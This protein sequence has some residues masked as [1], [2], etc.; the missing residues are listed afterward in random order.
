[1]TLWRA[2]AVPPKDTPLPG[3][4]VAPEFFEA[5]RA[6]GKGII[7]YDSNWRLRSG[8]PEKGVVAKFHSAL[9]EVLRVLIT[10]DQC[11]PTNLIS[12]EL[13]VRWVVLLETATS[14][15]PRQ[16][17]WDGLDIMVAGKISATGAAEVTVF[18]SW[19]T[20][21]QKDQAQVMKQ[22]RLLREERAAANKRKQDGGNKKD[23][24]KDGE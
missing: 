5:I 3:P 20:N 8:I 22:G 4:S 9:T 16:P 14:R 19:L 10:I 23:H 12:A 21:I 7:E 15:D 18:N 13:L 24:K 1:M 17:D 6:S 11:D 2:P